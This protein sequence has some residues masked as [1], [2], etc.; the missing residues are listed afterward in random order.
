MTEHT[1]IVPRRLDL[2]PT[3]EANLEQ[4][5]TQH[6]PFV[7]AQ[8]PHPE[9]RSYASQRHIQVM[10]LDPAREC[11]WLATWGG[12]LR[13][14]PETHRCVRHTSADG[15]PGNVTHGIVVDNAGVVWAAGQRA[16][17]CSLTDTAGWQTY[18]DLETR[19]VL[20]LAPRPDSGLYLAM[21]DAA[22]QCS[23]AELSAPDA[24]LRLLATKGLAIKDLDALFVAADGALWMGNPW[25]LHRYHLGQI[26]SFDMEGAQVRTIAH[27]HNGELW[28]GTLRGLYRFIAGQK[29]VREEGWPQ[30]AVISLVIEPDTGDLWGLTT[31]EVGRLYG[32]VW[33]PAVHLPAEPLTGLL[34]TSQALKDARPDSPLCLPEGYMWAGGANGFYKVSL[35]GYEPV[36]GFTPEDEVSNAVQSLWGDTA[37]V[38]LS[39]ARGL[40]HFDGQSWHGYAAALPQLRDVRAITPGKGEGQ[41]WIG[42]WQG[43]LL[44]LEQGVY[45]LNNPLTQP[46]VALTTGS[47]GSIWAATIDTIYWQAPGGQAWRPL[48]QGLPEEM[49]QGGIIQTLCH[50]MAVGSEGSVSTL[51][52][53]ATTGLFFYRPGLE[54]WEWIRG[55]LEK[56]PIQALA[57][58]PLT[59]HLWVGTPTGVFSEPAWNCRREVNTLALA[60]SPAPS[61]ALWIGTPAGLETWLAPGSDKELA[62][63]PPRYFTAAASGLAADKVTALA[64]RII[65]GQEEVW[66]GSPNGVSRYQ[67]TA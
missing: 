51:W 3:L 46:I 58:D 45:A 30:D 50:Q 49:L 39:A 65:A 53:G 23:L 44:A 8:P 59:N 6:C 20:C 40:S 66:V 26:E 63:Q 28:L 43:G 34:A 67:V 4:S 24:P 54:L 2:A 42:S 16:G 25:G 10:A 47:D 12:V 35:G 29:P 41:L 52:V 22:G 13:W 27:G 33:Q 56:T 21:R 18:R 57:L 7:P 11:I 36:L 61:G 31:R 17:L 9:W 19:T 32:D 62:G 1:E 55:D 15:L 14:H 37:G 38:W 5:R 60:F 48:P 64:I